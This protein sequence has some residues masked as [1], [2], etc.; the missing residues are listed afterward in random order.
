MWNETPES[1]FFTSSNYV[2]HEGNNSHL[3]SYHGAFH[4]EHAC[5]HV[6]GIQLNCCLAHGIHY[7]AW[8]AVCSQELAMSILITERQPAMYK[9]LQICR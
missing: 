5:W 9:L 4:V 6:Y 2:K 7:L 8:E 1:I 3:K